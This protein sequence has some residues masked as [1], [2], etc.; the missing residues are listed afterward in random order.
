M[1]YWTLQT[2]KYLNS[3]FHRSVSNCPSTE[4]SF[5][6]NCD[7]SESAANS[8]LHWAS[9]D[10]SPNWARR[11]FETWSL[12]FPA[13]QL[14]HLHSNVHRSQLSHP[15]RPF[16]WSSRNLPFLKR[17]EYI[18]ESESNT[19][20]LTDRQLKRSFIQSYPILFL[21]KNW[22]GIWRLTSKKS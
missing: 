20:L 18:I 9:V 11:S 2:A 22:I 10:T 3:D 6:P 1:Q 4:P 14:M 7:L 12:A 17:W 5:R 19:N 15:H 13:D 16:V 21:T 8:L